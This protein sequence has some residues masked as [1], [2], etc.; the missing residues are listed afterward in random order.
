MSTF[1]RVRLIA[2]AF[3]SAAQI[4]RSGHEFTKVCFLGMVRGAEHRR[5]PRRPLLISIRLKIA[6]RRIRPAKFPSGEQYK[7]W[8]L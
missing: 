6:D 2:V 8:R 1:P 5:L 3:I 7:Y 4:G